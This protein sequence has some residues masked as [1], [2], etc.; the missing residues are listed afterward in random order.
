MRAGAQL[1]LMATD[2]INRGILHTALEHPVE[3]SPGHSFRV[4]SGG[5]EGAVGRMPAGCWSLER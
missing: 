5:R 2:P 1:L 4:S 3:V